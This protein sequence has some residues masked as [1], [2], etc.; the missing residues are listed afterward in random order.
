MHHSILTKT[1]YDKRSFLIGWSLG[2]TLLTLLMVLFFPAMHQ[3]GALDGLVDKMPAAFKGIIGNLLDLQVFSTYLASQLFDIRGSVFAGVSAII[4]GLG[5]SATDEDKGYMRTMLALPLS[6][7]KVFFQKWLVMVL[8]MGGI[9][10]VMIAAI[11]VFAPI[12]GEN[13]TGPWIWQLG[14]MQWLVMVVFG[15]LTFAFGMSTGKRSVAMTIGILV[16]AGSF[17]LSTFAISVDWL[18]DY[19]VISVLHYFPAVDIAKSGLALT[20]I[21]ILLAITIIPTIIAWLVFRQRD[22]A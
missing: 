4:L 9:V 21:I 12:V 22:I 15:S 16:V 7:T 20:D 10:A 11:A 17:I 1:L 8:I 19:E 14:L 3:Q 5:L 13:V 6:R 18:K 2:F